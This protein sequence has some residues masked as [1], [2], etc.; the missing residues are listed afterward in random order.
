MTVSVTEFWRVGRRADPLRVDVRYQGAGRFDDPER[1]VPTLY[2]AP[3]LRT[4]LLEVFAPLGTCVRGVRDSRIHTS[5]NERR[6]SDRRRSRQTN[7]G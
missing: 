5:A 2:G 4:C 7:R 6:R 3:L 1:L